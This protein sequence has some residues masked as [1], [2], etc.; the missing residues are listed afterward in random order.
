MR[1]LLAPDGLAAAEVH[2]LYPGAFLA[3][4]RG[5]AGSIPPM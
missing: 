3:D 1:P 5:D 4:V 2:N